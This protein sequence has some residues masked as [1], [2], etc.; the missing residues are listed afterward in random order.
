MPNHV[1]NFLTIKGSRAD[2]ETIIEAIKSV[3][4]DH[5]D[6]QI[7]FDRI[8]PYPENFKEQDRISREWE[9]AQA[10]KEY[11]EVDWKA[12][13]KDGFN[14]G[15]YEWC[16]DNWGTKWNAYNIAGPVFE[17]PNDKSEY[18][19]AY[20]AVHFAFRTAW[21]AP[22]PWFIAL[23]EKFPHISFILNYFEC[24]M[25]VCGE[26][27]SANLNSADDDEE[28]DGTIVGVG[29]WVSSASQPYRGA[30]GG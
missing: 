28:E 3:D 22:I 13:P 23:T 24:G 16:C 29:Q 7:D 19:L 5:L 17:D 4:E 9:K 15:G 6:T 26:I 14:Q 30:R 20:S 12:R 21:S 2:L 8:L 10:D 25:G 27:Y 1:E 11:T 18:R